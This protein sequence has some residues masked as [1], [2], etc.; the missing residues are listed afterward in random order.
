MRQ[1]VTS[2]FKREEIFQVPQDG[3]YVAK[4]ETRRGRGGQSGTGSCAA[5]ARLHV[6]HDREAA[7][8]AAHNE[9]VGPR[10]RPPHPVGRGP[11]TMAATSSKT[12]HTRPHEPVVH[13]VEGPGR[14]FVVDGPPR[15][16]VHVDREA[17]RRRQVL[18]SPRR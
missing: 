9:F 12:P 2:V 14:G 4:V 8:D 13:F 7:P 18:I 16:A 1:V 10:V 11:M 5:G 15:Q 17:C 6:G 3:T